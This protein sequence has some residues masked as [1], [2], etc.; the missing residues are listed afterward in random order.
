MLREWFNEVVKHTG[1]V[2]IDNEQNQ[3]VIYKGFKI[4]K[5]HAGFTI[6]DVRKNDFYTDVTDDDFRV[7]QEKGFIKG[8]DYLSYIRSLDYTNS[9]RDEIMLL[10]NKLDYVKFLPSSPF[11]DKKKRN[12]E[13]NINKLLAELTIYQSRIS[14]YKLKYNE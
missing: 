10:Q 6:K 8:C 13:K 2:W 11:N 4:D 7:L 14:N 3:F 9:I 5:K 12:L 1:Y